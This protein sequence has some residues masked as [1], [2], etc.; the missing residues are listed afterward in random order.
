MIRVSSRTENLVYKSDSIRVAFAKSSS[1]RFISHCRKDDMMHIDQLFCRDLL[2]KLFLVFM[3][4][5]PS[6]V[7]SLLK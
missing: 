4:A 7:I 6:P 3:V 5:D 2:F 1:A